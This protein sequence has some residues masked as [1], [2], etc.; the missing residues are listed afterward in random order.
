MRGSRSGLPVAFIGPPIAGLLLGLTSEAFC[1]AINGFS[2]LALIAG[3]RA[4]N[5]GVTRAA[6]S[7]TAHAPRTS[8]AWRTM[9][10]ATV[11]TAPPGCGA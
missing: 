5:D 4:A 6:T 9:K 8:R 1:F 3:V 7:T 2:F 10:R 11:L